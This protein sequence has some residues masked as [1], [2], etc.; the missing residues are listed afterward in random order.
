MLSAMTEEEG[1]TLILNKLSE[2]SS[3]EEFLKLIDKEKARY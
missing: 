2:T 1:L 3:N